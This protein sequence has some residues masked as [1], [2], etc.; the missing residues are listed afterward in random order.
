MSEF[1]DDAQIIDIKSLNAELQNKL[2][3]LNVELNKKRLA[4]ESEK[5]MLVRE[6][7]RNGINTLLVQIKN[8]ELSVNRMQNSEVT[9]PKPKTADEVRAALGQRRPRVILSQELLDAQ[10]DE[11]DSLREHRGVFPAY[12]DKKA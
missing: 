3:M 8:T 10:R 12:K 2:D 5:S 6:K 11:D 7:L 9:Q 1:N 4:L